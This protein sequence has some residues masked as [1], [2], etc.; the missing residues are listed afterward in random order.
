MGDVDKAYCV[1]HRLLIPKSKSGA[2][3]Q[4]IVD[5]MFNIV[6][7]NVPITIRGSEDKIETWKRHNDFQRP[8]EKKK[9]CLLCSAVVVS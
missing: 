9:H 8:R 3:S 4:D 5:N 7:V 2:A 6:E 1:A